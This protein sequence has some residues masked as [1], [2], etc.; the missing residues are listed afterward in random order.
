MQECQA[1]S[2]PEHC[3]SSQRTEERSLWAPGQP[4]QTCQDW[5]VS[6]TSPGQT[7]TGHLV[8]WCSGRLWRNA[9]PSWCWGRWR[10]LCWWSEDD[11]MINL[12]DKGRKFQEGWRLFVTRSPRGPLFELKLE[13]SWTDHHPPLFVY[14]LFSQLSLITNRLTIPSR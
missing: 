8:T 12:V 6:R 3:N 1:G 11:W 13:D 10:F 7:V 14:N 9:W 4:I 2:G 5:L